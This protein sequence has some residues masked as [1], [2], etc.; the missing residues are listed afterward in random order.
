LER[1]RVLAP[2]CEGVVVALVKTSYT[3]IHRYR[4]SHGSR[5]RLEGYS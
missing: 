4:L 3:T 1:W 5:W 2:S